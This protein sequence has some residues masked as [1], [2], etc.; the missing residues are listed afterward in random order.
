MSQ[1]TNSTGDAVPAPAVDLEA[2]RAKLQVARY[3]RLA[4]KDDIDGIRTF[5]AEVIAHRRRR[6]SA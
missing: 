1:D 5:V 6:H 4:E 2:H 3:L